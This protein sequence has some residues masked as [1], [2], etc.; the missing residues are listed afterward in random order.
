MPEL[1]EHNSI[2]WQQLA[3][4]ESPLMVQSQVVRAV[5]AHKNPAMILPPG[6]I[7]NFA[8]WLVNSRTFMLDSHRYAT[9]SLNTGDSF[10]VCD[11]GHLPVMP[12]LSW[13]QDSANSTSNPLF[14]E[15]GSWV[16]SPHV[17]QPLKNKLLVLL[18][19]IKPPKSTVIRKMAVAGQVAP[20][21][22]AKTNICRYMVQLE[23]EA[24]SGM[25]LPERHPVNLIVINTS[26][27]K[28]AVQQTNDVIWDQESKV[29]SAEQ[30]DS[31]EV[32][33][34]T[35]HNKIARD[36]FL[37][38]KNFS[39][40]ISANKIR[41][42]EVTSTFNRSD[43]VVVHSVKYIVPNKFVEISLF[44]EDGLPDEGAAYQVFDLDGQLY[45]RGRLDENGY[46][47]VEGIEGP[48]I[49]IRFP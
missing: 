26:Q 9:Q 49:D 28:K 5:N 46:A 6:S 34:V 2:R 16:V 10:Y 35:E 18:H 15:N 31:I 21:V 37:D 4:L 7:R 43:E 3:H 24:E 47:R 41:P 39:A 13:K 30:G 17:Q 8:R 29:F 19:N 44:D 45:E 40:S 11:H 33:A 22:A 20:V 1:I 25:Q 48:D 32:F 42:L 23:I 14:G 38:N 27:D 36:D 12:L